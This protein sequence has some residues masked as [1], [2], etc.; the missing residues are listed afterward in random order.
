MMVGNMGSEQL[1][2]YTVM[3]DSVNLSARLEGANKTYQTNI[4]ISEFTYERVKQD[5]ACMELDSVRVKGKRLPV[6]IYQLV[7]EREL[8]EAQKEA[9]ERFHRALEL[10]KK[11]QWDEAIALFQAV[12]AIDPGVRAAQLY[13]QR[14][15]ELKI[16]PPPPDWD[17]V[18]TMTSK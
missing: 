7:G 18:F 5:F 2:D 13:I 16:S 3:G 17:G 11:Q 12:T 1:F 14:S 15:L 10:Y 8:P 6:K 9:V 4:L